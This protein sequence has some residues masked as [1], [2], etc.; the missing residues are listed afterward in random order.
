MIRILLMSN[1]WSLIV[2]TVSPI[3]SKIKT[4]TT[5]PSLITLIQKFPTNTL[6]IKC[7]PTHTSTNRLMESLHSIN[8]SNPEFHQMPPNPHS[9]QGQM[10]FYMMSSNINIGNGGPYP[11]QNYMPYDYGNYY[12]PPYNN[13]N[14]MIGQEIY[15]NKVDL[16]CKTSNNSR[17][18]S[19]L[20]NFVF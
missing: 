10:N 5:N 17:C 8:A 12:Y 3:F 19:K 7:Q 6:P 4:L 2:R 11:P 1:S 18:N 15:P 20:P 9:K 16:K 13:P 14:P